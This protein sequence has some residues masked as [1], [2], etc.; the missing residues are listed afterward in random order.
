MKDN[1]DDVIKLII[2]EEGGFVND[3]HDP[4]GMTNWGVTKKTLEDWCGHEVT[5]QAMRSLI[6]A[7]VYPLYKQRYW[8]AVGGDACPAG[9]DY[10]LMDYAV[11]SGPNRAIKHL[12][13]VLDI[14]Q[15]GK[16]DD[17]TKTA[18]AACDG[19]E[20]ASKLCDYRLE[21]LQKLPTFARFGKGWSA[22][23]GRVKEKASD[24]ED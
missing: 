15:T 4:G 12:Q 7:D 10:A 14:P 13:I 22:R 11:N 2:K 21:W 16:M 1:W 20:T 8:D 3:P 5:E 24:M 19:A 6:P 18:I 17:A 9:L 23:V